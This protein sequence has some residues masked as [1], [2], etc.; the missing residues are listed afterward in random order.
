MKQLNQLQLAQISGGLIGDIEEFIPDQIPGLELIGWK[1][2]QTGWD[3]TT[4]TQRGWFWDTY[5]EEKTPI[6]QYTPI[7]AA[8]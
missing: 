4:W 7:Y 3:T 1:R 6:Y 5:H 8:Y 2:E